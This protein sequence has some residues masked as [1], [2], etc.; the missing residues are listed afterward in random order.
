MLYLR[1][2]YPFES[3]KKNVITP[4]QKNTDTDKKSGA[5]QSHSTANNRLLSYKCHHFAMD[6]E[7]QKR[8]YEKCHS[9]PVLYIQCLEEFK[10]LNVL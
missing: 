8:L 1:N 3:A 6:T 4:T 5:G 7:L 10:I 9:L 2:S